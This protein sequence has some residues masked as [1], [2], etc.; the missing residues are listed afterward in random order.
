MGFGKHPHFVLLWMRATARCSAERSC[1]SKQSPQRNVVRALPATEI[2]AVFTAVTWESWRESLES[3]EPHLT[4]QAPG[5]SLPVAECLSFSSSAASIGQSV[6][7]FLRLSF[8]SSNPFL[9]NLDRLLVW[10]WS[11]AAGDV[12]RTPVRWGHSGVLSTHGFSAPLSVT[13][14]SEFVCLRPAVHSWKKKKSQP[15]ISS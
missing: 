5:F 9:M 6:I 15:L 8:G 4:I 13:S 7:P 1:A 12:A 14:D 3:A 10:Q 11:V 2:T